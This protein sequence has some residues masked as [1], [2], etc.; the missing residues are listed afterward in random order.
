MNSPQYCNF[1]RKVTVTKE[2]DCERC[3]LS[4]GH[5][6]MVTSDYNVVIEDDQVGGKDNDLGSIWPLDRSCSDEHDA[7]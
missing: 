7:K 2:W 5:V 4:K 3:G 6:E 1:C